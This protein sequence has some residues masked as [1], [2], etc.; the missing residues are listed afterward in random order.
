MDTISATGNILRDATTSP[1][2]SPDH[3]ARYIR[4][5]ASIVPLMAGGG[6]Y[7]TAAQAAQRRNTCS[8]W[9]RKTTS[10]GIAG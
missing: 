7:E 3:G 4:E 8:S 6:M 9:L 2:C 5:N 10:A 1:T